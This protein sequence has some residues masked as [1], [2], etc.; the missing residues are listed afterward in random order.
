MRL[1]GRGGAEMS[2][3]R[4]LRRLTALEQS[5]STA[6]VLNL[7]ATHR[8]P[9]ADGELAKA[10]FF[11]NHLLDRSIV[12]K[13][14]LRLHEYAHFGTPKPTATKILIPFDGLDLRLG[15]RSVFIG[16]RDFEGAMAGLFGDEV[17]PGSRDWR[18]LE[19]VDELPSLDPFLL[20]EHLRTNDIQPARGYFAI[21]DADVQRMFEFVRTEMGALVRLSSNE[22]GGSYAHASRLVDKLLSTS[23]DSEFEPLKETLKLNEREYQDG[24]FSWRGFLYYKWTLRDLTPVLARVLDEMDRTH[25]RGPSDPG[26]A[27][28]LP[29]AK[30]RIRAAA[31]EIMVRVNAMLDIYNQA[32]ASL[33]EQSKPTA[34][35]DF[36]LT[37]P[38][39]FR[40]LGE[41]LGALQHITSFWRYR[42]P[43]GQPR[44]IAPPELMDLFLDFEDSLGFSDREAVNA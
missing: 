22:R 25:G 6:R 5:A 31:D 36:L 7:L 17:R 26:A 21:S 42:F 33:T 35:R 34:F 27:A 2:T 37:A 44:V 19:L 18:V 43:P 28:Y 12:L 8:K 39:M 20:R 30:Q 3:D 23:P 10:P 11:E 29:E 41:Q 32:Y 1:A 24:V 14:R 15:A 38:T 40:D 4:T 9:D 13:H 16:E